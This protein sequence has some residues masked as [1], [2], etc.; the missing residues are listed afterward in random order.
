MMFTQQTMRGRTITNKILADVAQHLTLL[1]FF[2][3][4]SLWLIPSLLTAGQP[5]IEVQQIL[6]TAQSWD[7]VNYQSYPTGLPQLTVLRI[8]VPPN[9]TL[10]WHH[11]S[12]ISVGYVLSGELTLEKKATGERTILHSGEALG[13]TVQTT[14]RGF[15]TKEPVELIVFYAGLVGLPITTNDE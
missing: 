9:T 11:H 5:Q 13:E 2:L 6:Q 4:F 1:R 14:V 8:K 3:T 12:V 7:G 10:H 15:T